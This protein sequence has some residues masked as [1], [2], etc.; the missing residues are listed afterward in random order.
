MKLTNPEKLILTMLADVHEELGINEV[1]TQL[2]KEAIYTDNTWALT[3]EMSGI[4]GDNGDETPEEV[5]FV[6]DVLNMWS[7]L[8]NSYAQYTEHQREQLAIDADP[9]GARVHFNGFDGNNESTYLSIVNFLVNEMNRFNE[10]AGRDFNS[11]APSI[12]CY[13]RML[14]VFKELPMDSNGQPLPLP[15]LSRVLQARRA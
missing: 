3:W 9:F 1:N 13:R 7:V 5:K 10:F 8:E 4:V 11:H 15:Q 2:L 14:A 12:G 6:C